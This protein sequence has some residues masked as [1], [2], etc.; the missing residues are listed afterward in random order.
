MAPYRDTAIIGWK[1]RIHQF[2]D[3]YEMSMKWTDDRIMDGMVLDAMHPI[4]RGPPML[5]D[6]VDG[7]DEEARVS[8]F[9]KE[10]IT[11]WDMVMIVS[12]YRQFSSAARRV[13]PSKDIS[14][15]SFMGVPLFRIEHLFQLFRCQMITINL[16]WFTE[17]YLE[18]IC[19]MLIV[20]CVNYMEKLEFPM[21]YHK[22]AGTY[23]DLFLPKLKEISVHGGRYKLANLFQATTEYKVETLEFIDL[24]SQTLPS[25]RFGKLK[26]LRV[27]MGYRHKS[28]LTHTLQTSFFFQLNPQIERLVIKGCMIQGNIDHILQHIQDIRELE[29]NVVQFASEHLGPFGCFAGLKCLAR[30][31]LNLRFAT[32]VDDTILKTIL[33]TLHTS[34]GRLRYLVLANVANL[35]DDLIDAIAQ[36]TSIVQLKLHVNGDIS[37]TGLARLI[38]ALENLSIID[39]HFSGSFNTIRFAMFAAQAVKATFVIRLDARTIPAL[40]FDS[41][42]MDEINSMR[43][44]KLITLA[45]TFESVPSQRGWED[46]RIYGVSCDINAKTLIGIE[47]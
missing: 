9:R 18:L 2:A 41:G 25:K 14:A 8:L 19:Q 13:Y 22:F 32:Y 5:D 6:I 34:G 16:S 47:R 37:D 26:E 45:V 28:P 4:N 10:H 33:T 35:D 24:D 7:M 21:D 39:I 36:H 40:V 20:Y 1:D 44:Q 11:I 12:K 31:H 27:A 29:L 42:I 3:T 23:L 17:D 30:L 38:G 46:V 15:A 43:L